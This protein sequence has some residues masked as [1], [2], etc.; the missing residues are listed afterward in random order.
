MTRMAM[1]SWRSRA[2]AMHDSDV[3]LDE[4]AA[5]LDVD[6]A[7]VRAHLMAMGRLP[8]DEDAL[9]AIEIV[10]GERL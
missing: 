5:E 10:N 4:I 7:Q 1:G 8:F 6:A 2:R 3:P 9:H